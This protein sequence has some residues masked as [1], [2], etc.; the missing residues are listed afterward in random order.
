MTPVVL[1]TPETMTKVR[2]MTMKDYS[3]QTLKVLHTIGVLHIEESKE[4]TP[5]DKAAIESERREVNELLTFVSNILNYMPQEERKPLEEDVEVIYTRPFREISEE[6]KSLYNKV[7]KVYERTVSLSNEAQEL[8]EKRGYLEPL[9]NEINPRL[10]DLSFSG[11]YL[12]SKVFAV[13]GHTYD[14]LQ[15]RLG[16]LP[17]E[18][19]VARIESEVVLYIIAKVRDQK[20]IESMVSDIG[21]K[22]IQM[23]EED[24]TLSEFIKTANKRISSLGEEIGKLEAELQGKA[25]EELNRLLLLREALAAESERLAVLERASEARYVT[26]LEGWIPE[27]SVESAIAEL[28]ESIGYVFVD[29]RKPGLEEEPPTKLKN[30]RL[31]RPFQVVINL[32]GIPKYREWDPTPVISYSFA[33]FFGLMKGDVVYA[34]G[35]LLCAKFLLPKLV[36]DPETENFKLFQNLLYISG[37]AALVFGLLSGSYLGNINEFLG[38]ESLALVKF[39]EEIIQ[40]PL[41]FIVF[42][43]LLGI[44]HVNIAHTLALIKAVQLR[45]RGGIIKRIGIILLQFGIPFLLNSMLNANVPGFNS[46]LYTISSYLMFAGIALLI[47][48]TL[49]ESGG[50]GFILWIFDLT[51]ILGDIMS[52]SRLAGVGLATYYLASSFNLLADLFRTM[53]PGVFGLIVG[54]IIA[55]GVMLFGHLI[56]L[57]LGIITGFTHS[58]RLCFVE[59]LFKFYEGGG[60]EYTPFKLRKR[61]FVSVSLE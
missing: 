29:T 26:L 19:I 58:L 35:V 61:T 44:V 37:G 27:S 25:K 50:L 60:R 22:A 54:T 1:N 49:M 42:S 12:F 48:G 39:I 40:D 47:I 24:L 16:N 3:E 20:T 56:N 31:F 43:L 32:F 9:S 38:I 28:R 33:I 17:L 51:G 34:L 6:V 45:N 13:P 10:L 21:G 2:V 36:D 7:N 18:T 4:L 55:I 52:Y 5:I 57:F 30:P 23:P 53:I 11:D 8:I 46:Q 41:R 59:F 15:E 14:T